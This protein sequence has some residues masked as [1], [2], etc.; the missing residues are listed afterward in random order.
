MTGQTAPAIT[1]TEALALKHSLL[2]LRV[3]NE[4]LLAQARA[5]LG[6]LAADNTLAS[7]PLRE[8]AANAEYQVADAANVIAQIDAALARMDAGEFGRCAICGTPIPAERL[9]IRPFATTCVPC[10]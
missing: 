1:D 3:D 9:E 5:T 2:R 8:V 4:G 7:G 10:S 6:T